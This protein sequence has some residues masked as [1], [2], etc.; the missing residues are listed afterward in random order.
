MDIR[1]ESRVYE[2]SRNIFILANVS[3]I[4]R[5][6]KPHRKRNLIKPGEK[7]ERDWKKIHDMPRGHDQA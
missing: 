7:D 2:S 1:L 5:R 6:G 3:R 4:G